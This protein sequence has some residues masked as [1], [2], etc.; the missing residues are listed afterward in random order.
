M[1]SP[2]IQFSYLV[3]TG[4]QAAGIQKWDRESSMSMSMSMSMRRRRRMIRDMVMSL[5]RAHHACLC[6]RVS[7]QW[8]V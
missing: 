6:L 2:V 8:R 7:A 1:D 5:V 4:R 3:Q